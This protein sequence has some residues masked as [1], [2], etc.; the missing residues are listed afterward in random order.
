[1]PDSDRLAEWLK[2][3]PFP[4][5][6]RGVDS[7]S[8]SGDS[9]KTLEAKAAVIRD[10]ILD[11]DSED[12]QISLF[13][14][15]SPEELFF[16]ALTIRMFRRT[17]SEPR[18]YAIAKEDL[19]GLNCKES[20]DNCNI[21]C[22]W[23]K[24]RHHDLRLNQSEREQLSLRLAATGRKVSP[25]LKKHR[26]QSCLDQATIHRCY[27]IDRASTQCRKCEDGNIAQI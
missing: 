9:Q 13:L 18:V 2:E 7:A 24:T 17:S 26:L 5:F 23:T 6:I 12:N 4:F 11:P 27:S 14:V 25:K 1:M 10:E 21:P 8:A 3:P 15:N 19:A 16:I 20:S 22:L